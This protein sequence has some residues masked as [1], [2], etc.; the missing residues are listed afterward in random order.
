MSICIFKIEGL[1]FGRH[2]AHETFPHS[3]PHLADGLLA[4]PF[5]GGQ[6]I[7]LIGFVKQIDRADAGLHRSPHFSNDNP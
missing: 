3:Q 1:F 7:A 5:S 6:H 4:Q 2:Q